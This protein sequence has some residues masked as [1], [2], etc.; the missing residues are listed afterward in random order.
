MGETLRLELAPFHVRVLTLMT[1]IVEADIYTKPGEFQLPPKSI[2]SCIT[3][4]LA[5]TTEG[6]LH[7]KGIPVELYASK[8]VH[9]VLNERTGLVYRGKL[10][11]IMRIFSWLP[12]ILVV[13]KLPLL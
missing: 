5:D 13:R 2:Y 7:P 4:T 6:K 3:S 1:G 10:A 12:T 8:M 9:D 11:T